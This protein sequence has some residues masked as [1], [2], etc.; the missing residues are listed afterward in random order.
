MTTPP[1]VPQ[2]PSMP[3]VAPNVGLDDLDDP[4]IPDPPEDFGERNWADDSQASV[5]DPDYLAQLDPP[6]KDG[7]GDDV[8]DPASENPFDA[9]PPAEPEEEEEKKPKKKVGPIFLDWSKFT[10]RKED[11]FEA[12]LG[13]GASPTSNRVREFINT[14]R[15]EGWYGLY[16]PILEYSNRNSAQPHV[17]K[18]NSWR[19]GKVNTYGVRDGEDIKARCTAGEEGKYVVWVSLQVA[20]D[21]VLPEDFSESE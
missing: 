14:A 15:L 11:D 6:D 16:Y 21:A 5:A 3:P 18:I 2:P 8:H 9:L 4:Y 7:S 13:G 10:P 19:K 12:G 1:S 17:T 20:P